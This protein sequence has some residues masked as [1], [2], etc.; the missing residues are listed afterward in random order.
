M[1]KAFEKLTGVDIFSLKSYMEPTG[2]GSFNGVWVMINEIL[3]NFFFFFLNAVVGFFSL[4]I[5]ILENIDLYNLYKRYVYD[6][7]KSIWQ[8]FAGSN[9]GGIG[10]NSLVSVLLLISAIYLFFQYFFTRGNISRKVLHLCLVIMLGFTYFG[11]I[12]NSSGGLYILDTVD[13]FS[14]DVSKKITNISISYGDDKS[15][16]V[17]DSLADS[18]I[19]ETSYKA[20]LFVNTGQEN[21]KYKSSK[22]GKEKDF[23]DSKVL[24][25][26]KDG[27]FTPVKTKDREDYLDKLGDGANDDSEDN[28]WVSAV[29]DFIFIRTFYVIFKIIE[30]FV[31]AIPIILVQLLNVTAQVIVLMMILLFPFILLMSFIP[32]MQDLIFGALKLMFGGL[33]FPAITSLIT[34]IIFYIEKLVEGLITDGFDS[35]L[36]TLPSLVLFGLVFKLLVSVVAKASVYLLLWKYKGQLIQVILGSRARMVTDDI[37]RK[38]EA[39][40]TTGRDFASQA[41]QRSLATAQHLGNFALA[42]AGLTAGAIGNTINRFRPNSSPTMA[43]PEQ[44]QEET[45]VQPN[46]EP[47]PSTENSPTSP[48][49]KEPTSPKQEITA[50]ITEEEVS[51]PLTDMDPSSPIIEE[52]E[53]PQSEFEQLKSQ[54]LTTLQKLRVQSLEK[55]LEVYKD[56]EAMFTAQGSNAFTRNYRK[57]MTKDQKLQANIDRRNRLTQRLNELRGGIS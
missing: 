14:K 52:T 53:N 9:V 3:V 23:D 10:N 25:S 55:R 51:T 43:V 6:G 22:D 11:S 44:S 45:P 17:G 31:L 46:E 38:V 20:Y 48:D 30:A 49:I 16:K 28:R 57:T 24:G 15:V 40:V 41:P 54:R 1:Q 34:L 39:G 35:V 21:G 4:L 36:K 32:R 27:K 8:G 47:L 2:F 29:S 42:S 18:Y 33:A 26:S 12:A 5:R 19:A 56:P 37:G 50:P 13:N 7:A